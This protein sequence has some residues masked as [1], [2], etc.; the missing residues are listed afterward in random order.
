MTSLEVVWVWKVN[1]NSE[2]KQISGD[3]HCSHVSFSLQNRLG[4]IRERY[5]LHADVLCL[6]CKTPFY[7]QGL[8]VAKSTNNPI[9]TSSHYF[10]PSMPQACLGSSWVTVYIWLSSGKFPPS[11]RGRTPRRM[12][13]P[14]LK[15]ARCATSTSSS[16][17]RSCRASSSWGMAWRSSGGPTEV[18]GCGAGVIKVRKD[19]LLNCT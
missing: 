17:S 11:R 12:A 9:Q 1:R 2:K 16:R 5:A 14:S 13:W 3:G 8:K 10:S 15:W 4:W 18:G 6:T 19:G 7:F